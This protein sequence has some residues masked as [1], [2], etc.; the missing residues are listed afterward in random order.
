MAF[1]A[2]LIDRSSIQSPE[3]LFNFCRNELI[4]GVKKSKHP[5]HL[6]AMSSVQNNAP[7]S[8]MV[9]SRGI[10]PSLTECRIHSDQR[11]QKNQHLFDNPN[12]ALLYYSAPQKLQVRLTGSATINNDLINPH[13]SSSSTHS[14]LCYAYPTP[15]STIISE[16]TKESLHPNVLATQFCI[17][18]AKAHFSSIHIQIQTLDALWLSKSGHIRIQGTL[19]N[20]EWALNFVVA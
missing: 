16:P 14:Q 15:P 5:F 7:F 20:N 17:D 10:T 1:N 4:L 2:N 19:K 13:F 8:R 6:C 9:V 11:S 3:D 12:V 18:T